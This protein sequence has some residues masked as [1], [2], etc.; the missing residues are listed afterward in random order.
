MPSYDFECTACTSRFED[1]QLSVEDRRFPTTQPCP[2]CGELNTLELC[3]A[4]PAIG[5]GYRLGR[6]HL[7]TTWTDTLKRIRGKHWGSTIN[8]HGS[9]K[10]I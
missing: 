1:I 5:D 7:P 8:T 2:A 3:A 9:K 6:R 10:E 4:A